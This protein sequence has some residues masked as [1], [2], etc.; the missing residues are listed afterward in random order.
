MASKKEQAWA[1]ETGASGSGDPGT[2]ASSTRRS[3]QRSLVLVLC[4]RLYYSVFAAIIALIQPVNW[5]LVHSNALTENLPPPAPTIPY[6][7]FGVWERFD[8]LWYL[9]IS[10][11][12]YDRPEAVV[13]FPLYPILIRA[14]SWFLPPMAVALAIS[15]LAAFFTFWGLKE[16]LRAEL[17]P[18]RV[19]QT[20]FLCAVW[21]ASFIFFAAYPESTLLAFIVWSLVMARKERWLAAALLG[22]AASI[23]KA[24]GVLVLVPLSTM[25]LRRPRKAALL[26]VLVPL[27]SA[28]FLG[29]LHSTGHVVLSSA[30]AT[31]WRTLTALP[32]MTLWRGLESLVHHPTPILALNFAFLLTDCFLVARSQL[33]IEYLLY[34]VAAIVLF[35]SK[36]TTPPLESM[37]RYL[38]IVF[39]AFVGAARWLQNPRFEPRFGIVCMALFIMNCGLM[40]LFL[41]WSLVL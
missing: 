9:H 40:W 33:R 16:L 19:D 32:W 15:T 41:G 12:G 37:M 34:S 5:R 26:L 20:L 24:A 4:L 2:A 35:L 7:V 21:P 17:S 29:W 1:Q 36:E 3:W 31:Y 38:V 8:T 11:Q 13:F 6:L 28:L 22:F 39:P 25:A 30:Y 23:T 14:A 10:A 27:G 18:D